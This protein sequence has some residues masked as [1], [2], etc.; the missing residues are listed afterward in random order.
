M[1]LSKLALVNEAVILAA[2]PNPENQIR[3]RGE[4]R[5]KSDILDGT[6]DEDIL[7]HP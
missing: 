7:M 2:S 3:K 1:I 5:E 6:V 4:I